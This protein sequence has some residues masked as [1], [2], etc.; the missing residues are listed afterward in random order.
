MHPRL[1]VE[2][3]KPSRPPF[4]PHRILRCSPCAQRSERASDQRVVTSFVR[5]LKCATCMM[6]K[7]RVRLRKAMV[8]LIRNAVGGR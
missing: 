5:Q 8:N 3:E 6:Y 2:E 7:V 4:V 1:G